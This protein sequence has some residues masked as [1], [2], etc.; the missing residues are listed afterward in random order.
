MLSRLYRLSMLDLAGT[1][2]SAGTGGTGRGIASGL[3]G[4]GAGTAGI[5]G[6]GRLST[7]P[8]P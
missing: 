2:I 3:R 6:I 4:G 8:P 5:D 7:E 1:S